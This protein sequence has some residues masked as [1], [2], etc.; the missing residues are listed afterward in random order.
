MNAVRDK[1]LS[2]VGWGREFADEFV[3]GEAF[4]DNA[5]APTEPPAVA[6]RNVHDFAADYYRIA[7]SK[8]SHGK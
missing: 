3:R 6:V 7:V 2:A 1:W 4:E 8:T 5:V